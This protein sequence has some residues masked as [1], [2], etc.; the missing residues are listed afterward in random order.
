MLN[1]SRRRSRE[2]ILTEL[3]NDD[4]GRHRWVQEHPLS[5]EILNQ[6]A[7]DVM[8]LMIDA[9]RVRSQTSPTGFWASLTETEIE[10]TAVEMVLGSPDLW[11]SIEADFPRQAPQRLTATDAM[12]SLLSEV[13]LLGRSGPIVNGSPRTD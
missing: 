11:E 3:H 8:D 12:H 10:P 5:T 7:S 4:P 9:H 6:L 1:L 13:P 2:M